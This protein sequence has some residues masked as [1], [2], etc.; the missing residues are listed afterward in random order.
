MSLTLSQALEAAVSTVFNP[1]STFVTTSSVLSTTFCPAYCAISPQ[2]PSH[3]GAVLTTSSPIYTFCSHTLALHGDGATAKNKTPKLQ[4]RKLT[5]KRHSASDTM[6]VP[7]LT[8]AMAHDGIVFSAS[9][10][11]A[12]KQVSMTQ[13][14]GRTIA[15]AEVV[16]ASRPAATAAAVIV[17]CIVWLWGFTC[18]QGSGEKN[19]NDW[20]PGLVEYYQKECFGEA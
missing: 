6:D 3:A 15:W 8:S 20:P 7:S 11:S 5:L 19:G 16:E 9:V 12:L 1:D 10:T 13:S 4:G 14:R 2:Q 18:L 17:N